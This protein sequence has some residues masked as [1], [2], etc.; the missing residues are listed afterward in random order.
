MSKIK[1]KIIDKIDNIEQNIIYPITKFIR[2]TELIEKLPTFYPIMKKESFILNFSFDFLGRKIAVED[3]S[4]Y[5]LNNE[6]I[7][8]LI[9]P[10]PPLYLLYISSK[11]NIKTSYKLKD[12]YK[13]YNEELKNKQA[14]IYQET[15]LKKKLLDVLIPHNFFYNQCVNRMTSKYYY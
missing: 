12:L 8:I 9:E 2:Y 3:Y 14:F 7:E 11:E 4:N 10:A 5:I 1:I 13:Y 15:G 6:N